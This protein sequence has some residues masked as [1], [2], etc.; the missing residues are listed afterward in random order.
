M[1]ALLRLKPIAA[2]AV[3]K[4]AGCGRGAALSRMPD[5]IAL[6][7]ACPQ[8][9]Q[10]NAQVVVRPD[11]RRADKEG[12]GDMSHAPVCWDVM[13]ASRRAETEVKSSTGRVKRPSC[14]DTPALAKMRS[15]VSRRYGFHAFLHAMPVALKRVD[16]GRHS[17]SWPARMT[18]RQAQTGRT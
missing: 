12:A 1:A 7:L 10:S 2:A 14:A 18:P 9:V 15:V 13:P 16:M 4:A 6:Q 11:W 8:R 17:S 3:R 5:E